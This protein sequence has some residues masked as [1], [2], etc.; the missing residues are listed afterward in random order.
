MKAHATM[1]ASRF[2]VPTHG[3][4]PKAVL[5]ALTLH[6]AWPMHAADTTEKELVALQ[7][8]VGMSAMA[9]SKVEVEVVNWPAA[10]DTAETF[11]EP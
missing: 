2:A 6:E 1:T 8:G 5:E 11:G 4:P 10:I 7:E 3:S 9:A